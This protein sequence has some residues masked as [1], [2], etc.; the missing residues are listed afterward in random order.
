MHRVYP[1]FAQK[2]TVWQ[3]RH[4]RRGLP[5]QGTRDPYRIWVSE[6]MLQQTQVGAVIGYFQR[7]M[8]RF[9]DVQALARASEDE[10]LKH[11][12]GLGY[13]ARARNL[14]RTAGEIS[15]TYKGKFPATARELEALPGIGRSTAAA[16]AAFSFGE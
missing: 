14:H 10:V 2:L 6:I 3:R 4:G 15:R 16:I 13:Y 1:D 11:W 12:S 7:F 8:R 9:P 5:W